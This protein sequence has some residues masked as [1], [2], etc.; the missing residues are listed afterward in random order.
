MVM[1]VLHSDLT[2]VR[3]LLTI[4]GYNEKGLAFSTAIRLP[5]HGIPNDAASRGYMSKQVLTDF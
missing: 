2:R 1:V 3:L 5:L 4:Y